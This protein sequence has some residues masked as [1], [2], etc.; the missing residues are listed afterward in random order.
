MRV[1]RVTFYSHSMLFKMPK[2][3][4]FLRSNNDQSKTHVLYCRVSFN[5]T[6]SEFSLKEKVEPGE[7][8]QVYQKFTGKKRKEQFISTMIDTVNY[9]LKSLA[10]VNDNATAKELILSLSPVKTNSPML[11]D[12][13]KNYITSVEQKLNSTTIRNHLVKLSNLRAYQDHK[14]IKFTAENFTIVEAENFKE[15]FMKRNRTTFVDTANRNVLLFRMALI[16]AQKRGVIKSF[17]LIHYRG[18]KDPIQKPVFLTMQD[19]KI[20]EQKLFAS[21]MISQVKDLFLFQC[22]T[23]LSYSDIWSSWKLNETES[24]LIML[25]TRIKNNQGFF[26]P[27]HSKVLELLNKYEGSLPQYTNEVYNRI[28]KE[29][30]ELCGIDKRITTHTARKTF[31]TLK[32]S[33]GWTR[34]TVSK[35]LGHKSIRTTE[36]YYLGESFSRIE[37]E[38]MKRNA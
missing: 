26:V 24:G 14:K 16:W 37:N 6:K 10:L 20:L 9:K 17:E 2:I 30:A 29:I 34:E 33:E 31:A 25:G 27:V 5:G 8:D 13:V 7:W 19:L 12:I 3:T 22:Y 32:D 21:K 35:M 38:L 36:I 18:E 28:L 1:Q 11:D 4:F 15:W 23:G